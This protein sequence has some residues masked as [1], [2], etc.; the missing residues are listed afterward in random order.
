MGL[1]SE[2]TG[3]IHIVCANKEKA[4]K[5]MSQVKIIVRS[6]YSSPPAH[7]AKIASTI[8]SD[9]ILRSKWLEDINKMTNR[10]K[11]LRQLLRNNLE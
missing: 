4:E 3:A 1:Y 7:G 5:V 9:P 6:N 8:L 2:R 10:I 11:N